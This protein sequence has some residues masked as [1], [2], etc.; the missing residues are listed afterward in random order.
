M[1]FPAGIGEFIY[2]VGDFKETRSF[3]FNISV[4]IWKLILQS[5][6]LASLVIKKFIWYTQ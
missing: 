1:T 4:L 2:F 5:D 6:L 3:L